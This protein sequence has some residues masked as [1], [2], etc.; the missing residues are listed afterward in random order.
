MNFLALKI[1]EKRVKCSVSTDVRTW[2]NWLTFEPDPEYSPDARTGLLSLISFQ[3]C[4]AEFHVGKIQRTSEECFQHGFWPHDAMH[5]RSLCRHA[6][7]VC[8]SHGGVVS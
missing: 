2:T 3:R 7:S 8:L 1:T 5:K 4:Y 6:V